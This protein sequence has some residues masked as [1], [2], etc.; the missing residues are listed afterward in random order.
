ML[1]ATE[2]KVGDMAEAISDELPAMLL[3]RCWYKKGRLLLDPD[4]PDEYSKL[5]F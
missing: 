4:G 3:Y 5:W 2:L 1:V